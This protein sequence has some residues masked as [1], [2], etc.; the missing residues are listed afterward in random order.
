[1]CLLAPL[2]SQGIVVKRTTAILF[3]TADFSGAVICL[4]KLNQ[5]RAWSQVS[6]SLVHVLNM[7][8]IYS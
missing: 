7:T 6:Q 8:T 1:M 2:G 3:R 5:N 4:N